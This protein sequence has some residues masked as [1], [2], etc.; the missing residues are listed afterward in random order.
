MKFRVH[1][2]LPL[3]AV[4]AALFSTEHVARGETMVQYFNTSWNEIALKMPE[5]AEAGYGAI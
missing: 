3:L 5:L 1:L 4:L 2:L